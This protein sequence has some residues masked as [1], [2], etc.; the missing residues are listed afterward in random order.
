MYIFNGGHIEERNANPTE[1][2]YYVILLR[3]VAS[4]AFHARSLI[5]PGVLTYTCQ[6]SK[7]PKD[8]GINERLMLN[9]MHLGK[10]KLLGHLSTK[11]ATAES[12]IGWYN[13]ATY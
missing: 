10:N 9:S 2:R 3:R 12:N 13:G 6:R 5:F 4:G 7:H 11:R 1:P 8:L